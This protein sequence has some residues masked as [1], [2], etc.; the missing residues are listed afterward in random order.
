DTVLAA[1][2]GHATYE[3]LWRYVALEIAIVLSG[4]I[5]ARASSLT[6]SLL[7]D[8]FSNNMSIELMEHAA[9]LDLA[10]F[11]DPTFYDHLER[12]RRQ[13]VGRIALLTQAVSMSQDAVTLM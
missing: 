7:S 5:L 2:A 10:Q 9:T 6:E 11:E 12:A 13:T 1:R 3:T 4:E 8:L